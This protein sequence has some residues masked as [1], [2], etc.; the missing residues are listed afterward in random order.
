MGKEN[1]IAPYSTGW[2]AGIG[3][4]RG[5]ATIEDFL[6][7]LKKQGYQET[8]T[9][10]DFLKFSDG[11]STNSE[12]IVRLYTPVMK[13]KYKEEISQGR[14]PV[15]IVGTRYALPNNQVEVEMQKLLSSGL[16]LEQ[17]GG[18]YAFWSEKKKELESDIDGYVAWDELSKKSDSEIPINDSISNRKRNRGVSLG[19][20]EESREHYVQMKSLNIKVWVYSHAMEKIYDI[21]SWVRFCSTNKDMSVGGFSIELVPTDTLVK[22]TFGEDFSSHFN[23]TDKRGSLNRDW[24]SKFIQYNDAVFIRFE[25][26]KAEKYENQEEIKTDAHIVDSSKMNKK[27][28]W[29]MI[30]LVDSV[31]TNVDSNRTDYSI[32]ISGRDLS[33]LL[34]E[35]GSYFIPLKYV[36]GSPDRWFYGGNPESSWFKRNMIT[37][38]YY[39]YYL[40]YEFQ[41]IQA[42]STFVID[43][44]SNI[45]IIPDNVFSHCEVRPDARGIWK[46]IRMLV[47]PQLNERRVVDR[48][49]TN[50]E[51]TLMDFFNKVCQQPFVEF[52]GDTWGN[53]YDFVARQPPFTKDAISSVVKNGEYIGIEPKDLISCSLGYDNCVYSWYRLMP[54]NALTGSSQFSSL[55]LVPIIF[56]DKYV[57]RFGNKRCVTNDIYISERS[58]RGREG[59]KNKNTLSEA[60]V[61]DLLYVVETTCYL[62]FTRK[63]TITINGDRR[64]K[65]GTFIILESTQELFYVTAVNNSVT[66]TNDA[67]DRVTV[68]TVERGMFLEFIPTSASGR[69]ITYF[70]VVNIE[71][72][73]NSIQNRYLSDNSSAPSTN[74]VVNS[75]IFEFFLKRDM[76]KDGSD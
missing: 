57:E 33:K 49:L 30:G 8:L 21:S 69:G 11:N 58:L 48:S 13:E 14:P 37:G 12:E 46:L 68:L 7:N 1:K 9:V 75:E 16:F 10:D 24:F 39:N 36:Q 15:I 59:E 52:W 51:G 54:Q 47:D 66:F 19:S 42:V 61:N 18:F 70:D 25:K 60:L 2:F 20:G 64:I 32:N 31:L 34:V 5:P 45:G 71:G 50:P 38:A 56:L 6:D 40:G 35:D 76:F 26:L 4:D 28:I 72:L 74:F 43:H 29:D 63:G 62:P 67:V 22:Q 27:L 3:D 41:S 73:R 65:V 55:A 23:I 53:E 17:K 44:L